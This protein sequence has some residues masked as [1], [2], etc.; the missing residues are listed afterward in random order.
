MTRNL[1]LL[2]P[3]HEKPTVAMAGNGKSS[4]LIGDPS[5][6]VLFFDCYVLSGGANH[7]S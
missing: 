7:V 2:Q 6:H 3:P 5:S 1:E 4:F